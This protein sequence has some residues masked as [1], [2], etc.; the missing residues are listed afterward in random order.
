[1]TLDIARY[2]SGMTINQDM[3][4]PT[5]LRDNISTGRLALYSPCASW[6]KIE[7]CLD[8]ITG[9]KVNIE[10]SIHFRWTMQGPRPY[11]AG[12]GLGEFN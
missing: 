1:M 4:T 10:V 11:E 12:R 9:N 6:K 7:T 5:L 3:A 2:H 8:P